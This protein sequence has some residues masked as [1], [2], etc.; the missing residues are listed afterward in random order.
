MEKSSSSLL[1]L[2]LGIV[3]L[4][5]VGWGFDQHRK[6]E[7]A[8]FA[9]R[10]LELV[11]AENNRLHGI[12]AEQDKAKTRASNAEQRESI[13]RAVAAIRQLHFQQPVAYEVLTR[14]GIKQTIQQK[15]ADQYS[16][17]EFK[18]VATGLAA[19]GLIDR[20]YPLKQKYIELLGEQIAAFYDQ[21]QHKLCMFEDASLDNGQ[22]RIVLAHELTHA[23]QDQNFG[24]LKLPLETKDNDDM[25]LAASALVEG[26]ATMAMAEYMLQNLSLRVLRDNL[27]GLMTQNM[28]QLQKAP[29]YLRETLIFPYLR[30]QEFCAALGGYDAISAAFKEPPKSTAQILHPEKYLA[31]PR[32]D[33]IPVEFGDA[34]V[35]GQKPLAC[36][37]AGELGTRILISE[38]FDA[39]IAE[40]AAGG[41]RGDRYL[42]FNDGKAL[43]WKS[44]WNSAQ[45]ANEFADA[46]QRCWA[47]R[48]PKP[49]PFQLLRPKENEVVMIDA[50]DEKW[51]QALAE[52]FSK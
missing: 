20:D 8:A 45:D 47:K 2:I 50:S 28:E 25:A 40:T 4:A 23:L 10:R 9:Q 37:V 32:E 26:D 22:N 34:I 27:A 43:V 48:Y 29:R 11:Q 44:V 46:I 24:L 7:R 42:V 6:L 52:K 35:M 19:L 16:D 17:A 41:W 38:W 1:V 39:K 33:P 36:N 30:G 12:L 18:N 3:A 14:A 15:L 13:E 51:A 21:H 31:T 5:G 49:R